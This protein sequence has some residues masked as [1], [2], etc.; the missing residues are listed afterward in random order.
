MLTYNGSKGLYFV[1]DG[2]TN[3]GS[4]FKVA[5][6]WD[7][8]L[9]GANNNTHFKGATRDKVLAAMQAHV[10]AASE[11]IVIDAVAAVQSLRDVV[12]ERGG[13]FIYRNHNSGTIEASPND[14]VKRGLAP[15]WRDS[16]V[17]VYV[18]RGL[19]SCGV[20]AA[21]AH[22]GVPLSTLVGLDGIQGGVGTQISDATIP[23]VELT[24]AA[25]SIYSAFQLA[26][27]RGRTWGHALGLAE[28]A[29]V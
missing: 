29:T 17:C 22:L 5:K 19:A 8:E 3:V 28:H 16:A 9:L 14:G 21:L 7:G 27:D 18:W 1:F 11:P 25:R 13:D 15:S 6:V 24:P 12:A 26:Q 10:D 20:G 2:A 4:I 23:G